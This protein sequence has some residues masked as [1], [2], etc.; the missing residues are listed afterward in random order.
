MRKYIFLFL[1]I[2]LFWSC[3]K[4]ESVT[5]EEEE[6]RVSYNEKHRPQ[7]HF[8]PIANWMN[9]PNGMVY[10][11]GEY[12]LFY[13]Y[14]PDSTV[15]GPM[16]WG[17]AISKDLVFWEH[18]PIALYPDTLGY[19]FSGSVVVDKLNTSSLGS[20]ENPPMVALFT[21]HVP[22]VEFEG[23]IDYQYQGMAYSLDNGRT[24]TKYENNPVLINPGI[25]DFR[26][27]K[28]IWHEQTSQWIMVLA[29]ADHIRFYSSPDLINWSLESEF[30]KNEGSHDGV[31]ECPDLFE[32][33]VS[34]SGQNRWVLLVSIGTGGLR[35]SA[36]QYFTGTFDGSRFISDQRPE[37]VK[38]I[39]HGWDNY[40]GVTWSDLPPA[41]N[42]RV[43][44]G[45]MSN[46]VYAQQV[47]THPWRSA[48]TI[49]RT[50]ELVKEGENYQLVTKPVEELIL[51]R[52]KA[53]EI[54]RQLVNI[55]TDWSHFLKDTQGSAELEFATTNIGKGSSWF[56]QLSNYYG[57][58]VSFGFDEKEK[59]Y[60]I[61]RSK[62]RGIEFSDNYSARH[63][64]K[65]GIDGPSLYH[66]VF[67]DVSSIEI[68]FN[69]GK[70]VFT[71][72]LFPQIPF[73]QMT[74]NSPQGSILVQGNVYDLKSI[75]PEI[76]TQIQ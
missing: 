18:Q 71:E 47:P 1:T 28:V 8:T 37:T 2:P 38:W 25:K 65:R 64:I 42:R 50:L 46:W 66:R 14:Y 63:V 22:D 3:Q 60:Y 44:L 20:I 13:Q 10:Y 31:W 41:Q 36:T 55:T 27:P 73:H 32:L 26:D 49:P 43:F 30:G 67:L 33:N 45:W 11:Q 9:D 16:H 69:D 58:S 59:I 19:I 40:A 48:M 51:L 6:K 61:D 54:S 12:H 35:G 76:G 72:L 52:K 17:H 15:W 29:V 62:I 70:V 56:I 68:F 74:F 7:Y 57:D 39:D 4:S 23:R 34:N 21:Y 5:E 75:W 24:W 53:M